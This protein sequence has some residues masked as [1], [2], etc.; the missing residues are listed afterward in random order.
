MAVVQPAVIHTVHS[1]LVS[2]GPS[3]FMVAPD[4]F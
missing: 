2:R 3:F 1:K 4:R